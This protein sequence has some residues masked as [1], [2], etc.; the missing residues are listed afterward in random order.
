M[1]HLVPGPFSMYPAAPEVYPS[2]HLFTRNQVDES[3]IYCISEGDLTVLSFSDKT[4]CPPST[5]RGFD[6]WKDAYRRVAAAI[7]V[8]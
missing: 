6:L 5:A 4:R 8:P 1:P 3:L 7:A 2:N